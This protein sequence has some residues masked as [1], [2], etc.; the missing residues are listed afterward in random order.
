M[1]LYR[2]CN[3][4]GKE[5]PVSTAYNTSYCSKKCYNEERES[6]REE[7]ERTSTPSSGKSILGTLFSLIFKKR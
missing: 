5:I 3:W 7:K 1:S 2:N 4:C 6:R